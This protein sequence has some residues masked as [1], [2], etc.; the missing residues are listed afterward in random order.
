MQALRRL[1][2]PV[3]AQSLAQETGV[4]ERTL[5][6]DI[7][8]LRGLGAVIDGAAGFGYTLIE[9]ASLPPLTFEDN[10][11]EALV[12]GLR[13]VIEIGDPVLAGA[14]EAAL[15][16]LRARLPD[17]QAHRLRHA[18]LSAHRFYPPPK[19]TIDP[20]ALRQAVW[21]ERIVRFSYSDARGA[22]TVRSVKPLTITFFESSHCLMSWCL[23]REGFR[24]FRL[25]R[26]T[27]LHVTDDS[28]RP[29]RIP[30]LRAYMEMITQSAEHRDINP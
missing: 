20:H 16:K 5:Y 22:Q 27:D 13:E 10:E 9:D 23:L 18:V 24:A 11:L 29:G 15:G 1:T 19:P 25:D 8:T 26:M 17:R 28:F 4:S 21:E 14:A 7:E 3:T 12:L 30:L 6:R 2:P